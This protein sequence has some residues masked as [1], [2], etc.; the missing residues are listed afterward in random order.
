MQLGQL[1]SFKAIMDLVRSGVSR[2]VIMDAP[3]SVLLDACAVCVAGKT[4]HLPHKEGRSRHLSIWS[5]CMSTLQDRC[6]LLWL[7]AAITFTLSMISLAW[8]TLI[9]CVSS[10][11]LS[12]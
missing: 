5:V 1:V 4:M 6:L 9:H 12:T 10:R 2:M 11:R 8:Y 3:A 7:V